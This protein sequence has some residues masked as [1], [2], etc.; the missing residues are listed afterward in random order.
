MENL[1]ALSM[2]KA[3]FRKYQDSEDYNQDQKNRRYSELMTMK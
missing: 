2:V 3:E 1:D